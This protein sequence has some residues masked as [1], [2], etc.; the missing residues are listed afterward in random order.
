MEK[1]EKKGKITNEQTKGQSERWK[2]AS[3]KEE[4][5]DRRVYP[6]RSL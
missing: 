3:F 1:I 6:A 5:G 4:R 2:F